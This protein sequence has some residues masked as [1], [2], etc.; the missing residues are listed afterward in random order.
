MKTL[1]CKLCGLE[2]KV[3]NKNNHYVNCEICRNNKLN[4]YKFFRKKNS[5]RRIKINDI[6]NHLKI[7]FIEG[8]YRLN[9]KNIKTLGTIR[10]IEYLHR[11]KLFIEETIVEIF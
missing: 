5:T 11:Y 4:I 2:F 9:F 1:N 10:D 3:N 6:F 8:K 7:S